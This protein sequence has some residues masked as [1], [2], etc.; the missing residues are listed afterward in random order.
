MIFSDC[1]QRWIRGATPSPGQNQHPLWLEKNL[2]YW[3]SPPGWKK[4]HPLTNGNHT[5][6]W[7]FLPCPPVTVTS[8]P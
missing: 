2:V 5:H 1:H 8:P 6:P 7:D 3:G 4:F